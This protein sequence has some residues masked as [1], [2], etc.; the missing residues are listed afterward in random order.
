MTTN[1]VIQIPF[2]GTVI[3]QQ[4]DGG[5]VDISAIVDLVNGKR[6][7]QGKTE[8]TL[9]HY[10]QNGQSQE[11]LIALVEDMDLKLNCEN[12]QIAIGRILPLGIDEQ[13]QE[14]AVIE[15]QEKITI[16]QLKELQLYKK[17]RGKYEGTW[18]TPLLAIDIVGWL[19]PEIKLYF[20]K[21]V[22]QQLFV[23]R[24]EISDASLSTSDAIHNC[25]GK[26]EQLFWLQYNFE[27]NKKII[28]DSYPGI[29]NTMTSEEY[30]KMLKL[31]DKVKTMA[32]DYVF[33]TSE[34]VIHYIRRAKIK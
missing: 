4:T 32:E 9:A 33:K 29:R 27:I 17:T 12:P 19:D 21:L 1:K 15:H 24:V 26:Q 13:N 5:L 31:L 28:G 3:Q 2:M 8:I 18:F 6:L 16:E 23:K 22:M 11:Y 20:N 25:I 30:Q 7:R 34:D 14:V 10:F